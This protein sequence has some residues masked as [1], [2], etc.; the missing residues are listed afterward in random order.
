MSKHFD[1]AVIGSGPSGQRAAIQASK[2]G[3]KTVIIEKNNVIGGAAINT[4][5]IPSKALREAVIYL[6]GA[7]RHGLYGGQHRIKREISFVDLTLLANQVINKELLG[8]RDAFD[9]NS[10]DLI[11]GRACFE[12][13]NTLLIERQ[14]DSETINA[15]RF[16]I[17]TGTR[18]ARPADVPF[19]EHSVFCSDKFLELNRIPKSMIVVGGGVIGTEY[20]CILA[21]L[22]VRV[23]LVEGRDK[24]LDFL[25]QEIIESLQHAMRRMG[26]TLRLGEKVRKIEEVAPE[27]GHGQLVRATLESGKQLRAQTL[28][29]TVGRQGMCKALGLEKIGLKYDDRE[30]LKV[31]KNFQTELD[32]IYAVGDVVGFPAL[33]STGMEQGRLA[34]CHAFGVENE[35]IPELLPYGIYAVPEISMVGKTEKQ[36]TDA[37]IPYEAGVA[38]YSEI[39]RGQLLGDETGLLKLLIH[40][41]DRTILGVH[42]IGTGAT[43]LIHIGQMVMSFKGKIDDLLDSVFNYPTLA[44]AYK[45]AAHNGVNKLQLT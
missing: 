4:G 21:T 45:V 29:Y 37:G 2:L 34:A 18:P 23:T 17:A 36:L 38:Q 11:W 8:I 35:S 20:A 44:E 26:I 39:A 15:D 13:T 5:T 9:R 40:Q 6:T 42:C 10:I 14:E 16:I 43:E 27:N 31:N 12:N 32:H 24:L 33:A 22:G 41:D 30:R 3:K 1:L 19:N 25:D 7:S 28:L